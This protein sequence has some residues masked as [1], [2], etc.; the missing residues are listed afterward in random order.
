[1]LE[2]LKFMFS[3]GWTFFGCLVLLLST[4]SIIFTGIESIILAIKQQ[5]E[6]YD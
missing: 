6:E 4:L 5:P 2:I 3:S 1:M